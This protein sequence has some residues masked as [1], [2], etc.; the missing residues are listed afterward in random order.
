MQGG[1]TYPSPMIRVA[2]NTSHSMT[3]LSGSPLRAVHYL[4]A[5]GTKNRFTIALWMAVGLSVTT[6]PSLN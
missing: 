4:A 6:R 2:E 5:V 3:A 1:F